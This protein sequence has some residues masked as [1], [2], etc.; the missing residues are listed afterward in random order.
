[1]GSAFSRELRTEGS[2][3]SR[4]LR[5]GGS[6][7]SRELRTVGSSISRELSTDGSAISRF[8][9]EAIA[10]AAITAAMRIRLEMRRILQWSVLGS[11]R[12]K[13][14]VGSVSYSKDF[15]EKCFLFKKISGCL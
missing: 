9:G 6:N 12:L 10:G 13:I 4:A 1:M 11:K 2:A 7:N 3:F 8:K 5:T 15:D 14:E